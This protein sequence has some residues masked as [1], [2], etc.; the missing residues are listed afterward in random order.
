MYDTSLINFPLQILDRILRKDKD[1][2]K[3][4]LV[5]C[6][7]SKINFYQLIFQEV[8]FLTTLPTL[9]VSLS[10]MMLIMSFWMLI[11]D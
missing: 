9:S 10:I 6:N 4:H 11:L 5:G 2:L 8:G 7:I 1:V 3:A